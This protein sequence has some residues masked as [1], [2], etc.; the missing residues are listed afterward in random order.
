MLSLSWKFISLYRTN[1]NFSKFIFTKDKP[2]PGLWTECWKGQA[3]QRWL[4][5]CTVGPNSYIHII[6]THLLRLCVTATFTV[7]FPLPW[8]LIQSPSWEKTEI[9]K[10]NQMPTREK[11]QCS[12]RAGCR[13]GMAAIQKQRWKS[14]SKKKAERTSW[15]KGNTWTENAS[16]TLS[17]GPSRWTLVLNKCF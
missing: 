13:K 12:A 14:Q 17:Q 4:E 5:I 10:I 9:K 3:E 7:S 8:F 15:M 6:H 1:L 2:H 11:K 16:V